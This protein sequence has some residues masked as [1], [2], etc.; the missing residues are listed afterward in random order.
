[1]GRG[2]LGVRENT[3]KTLDNLVRRMA[4]RHAVQPPPA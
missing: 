2:A 3:E 1:V 4:A